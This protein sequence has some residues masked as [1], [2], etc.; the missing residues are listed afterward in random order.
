[1]REGREVTQ[2]D[3]EARGV[4]QPPPSTMP[5]FASQVTE[6]GSLFAAAVL[7]TISLVAPLASE[8]SR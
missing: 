5:R 2:V 8:V 7:N 3:T 4:P 1:M 6:T